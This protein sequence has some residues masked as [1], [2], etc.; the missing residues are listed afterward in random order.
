MNKY[1]VVIKFQTVDGTPKILDSEFH[2]DNSIKAGRKGLTM[3]ED[4]DKNALLFSMSS[5]PI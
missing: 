3:I 1:N 5:K 2:A 4:I